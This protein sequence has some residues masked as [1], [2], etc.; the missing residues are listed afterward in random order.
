MLQAQID[1][2]YATLARLQKSGRKGVVADIVLKQI[3]TKIARLENG[4]KQKRAKV[5]KPSS[6]NRG[7][8]FLR[9]TLYRYRD[10]KNRGL[11]SVYSVFAALTFKA[12]VATR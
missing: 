11:N 5:P 8:Q 4:N 2:E 7:L 9:K 6:A 10:Y 3:Q 1:S 12:K